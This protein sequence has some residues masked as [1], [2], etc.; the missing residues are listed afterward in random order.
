MLIWVAEV[1]N[2]AVRTWRLIK[3]TAANRARPPRG[4]QLGEIRVR[5]IAYSRVS[6][7]HIHQPGR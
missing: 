2:G 5:R 3:D 1:V 4:R 7:E 6:S